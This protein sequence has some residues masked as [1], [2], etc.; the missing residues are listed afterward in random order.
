MDFLGK[1]PREARSFIVSGQVESWLPDLL[2]HQTLMNNLLKTE[3][4][5]QSH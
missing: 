1:V 4:L 3:R 2:E 5:R